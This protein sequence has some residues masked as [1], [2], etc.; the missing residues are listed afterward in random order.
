MCPGTGQ[1]DTSFSGPVGELWFPGYSRRIP[2][3]EPLRRNALD[4]DS[5][6]SEEGRRFYRNE[7][8][9]ML[10]EAPADFENELPSDYRW[11]TF[12]Q[13]T[14]LLTHSNYVNIQLRS[15]IACASTVYTRKVG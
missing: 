13:L 2:R 4:H 8:R 3:S 6:Q 7:N 15:V 9:Y 14:H 5:W 11:M 10:I 12:G 1:V